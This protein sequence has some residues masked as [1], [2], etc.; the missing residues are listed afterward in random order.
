MTADPSAVATDLDHLAA[1]IRSDVTDVLDAQMDQSIARMAADTPRDRGVTAASYRHDRSAGGTR[2][3]GYSDA[4][5]KQGRSLATINEFGINDGK[6][7]PAV[8]RE[9]AR[10]SVEVP[11]AVADAVRM[12]R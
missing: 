9:H 6:P 2:H 12:S 11:K 8:E 7:D 3:R 1:S 4:T 10:A 5:D